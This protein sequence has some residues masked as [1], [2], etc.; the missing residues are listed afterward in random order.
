M[1]HIVGGVAPLKRVVAGSPES[2][3]DNKS[4]D[5]VEWVK[6]SLYLRTKLNPKH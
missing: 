1:S 2:E 4:G 5:D 6:V 3:V